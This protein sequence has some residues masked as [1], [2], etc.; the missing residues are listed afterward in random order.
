MRV[1]QTI[2]AASLVALLLTSSSVAGGAKP[3]ATW[4][5]IFDGSSL[6]GWTP[7]ITGQALGTD[8]RRTFSVRNGAIVVSYSG[9][10]GRFAGQFGHLAYAKPV[11][12]FR[13][14]FEYRF[15]GNYLA[16]V[17][18]WQ[19]ANSGVMVLAQPPAT[20]ARD[21]KFPVSIEVQLLG[22]DGAKPRSTGNLCTPGTNIVIAGKLETEHCINSSSATFANGRWIQAEVEV[23]R[24]GNVV[25]RIERKPVLAYSA[26]QLDPADEDARPLIAKA[27][28]QLKLTRGYLYLQ[29]EGH[30]VEFR[31]IQLMEL[32]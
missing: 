32:D 6:A 16:D 31:K 29:S 15:T 18:G 10:H 5:P 23:D 24:R 13:L 9:Y 3:A 8:P 4:R 14:R 17:E 1:K 7:K 25:H 19:H 22:A 30:P 21:Q 2:C 11:G 28:G 26:P 27:G 12:A 20:M